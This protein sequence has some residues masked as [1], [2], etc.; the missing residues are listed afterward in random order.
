MDGSVFAYN[1]YTVWADV[2][3]LCFY[4]CEYVY[5]LLIYFLHFV[6]IQDYFPFAIK[7]QHIQYM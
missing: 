6:V 5:I 3:L 4:N 7:K 1:A 2:Q